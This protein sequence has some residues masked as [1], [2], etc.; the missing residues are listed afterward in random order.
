MKP[1]FQNWILG[2]RLKLLMY[3]G[4]RS[5]FHQIL[6]DL[7]SSKPSHVK[8]PNANRKSLALG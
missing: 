6:K 7:S 1:T 5:R 8:Q 2:Y 3:T 4:K